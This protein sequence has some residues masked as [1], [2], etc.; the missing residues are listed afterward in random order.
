MTR[1]PKV[2]GLALVAA[3]AIAAVTASVAS[4]Q[5]GTLTSTGPVTLEGTETGMEGNRVTAFGVLAECPGSTG[6]GH[7]VATTPHTFVPS[8]STTFTLTPHIKQVTGT[9]APN[10]K[11]SLG[12]SIT[13]DFNGCDYVLHIGQTTGGLANT[14]GGTVDI[15]CPAGKEILWTAWLSESAHTTEPNSPKCIF[16]IPPQTGL[17]GAHA[18]DTGNGTI[19]VTGT[20]G[21]F[22]VN[23][24]RNSILCPQG[25]H[26]TEAKLHLD[27]SI[28]GKNEAG[29]PTSISLSD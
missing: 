22:T 28:A 3:T 6:T 19:D 2:L 10:C 13:T 23:Q 9:G 17:T 26:T 1:N 27:G 8:G 12:I 5:Q 14:Y 29:E 18:S 16:H 25:T 7:K 24:T 11:A 4:A 21:G 15:V 20:G